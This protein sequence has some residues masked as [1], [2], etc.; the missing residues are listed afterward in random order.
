MDADTVAVP[1]P[2]ATTRPVGRSGLSLAPLG[3]GLRDIG[4]DPDNT[5]RLLEAAV[6]AGIRY[7]DTAAT[8]GHGIAETRLGS[9]LRRLDRD[10][11]VISIKVG[12]LLRPPSGLRRRVVHALGETVTGGLPGMQL[13]VRRGTRA[14]S[15][16]ARRATGTGTPP[17]AGPR[18]APA[19]DRTSFSERCDY[20]YDG[21][22]R[23]FEESLGRLGID[24]VGIA[25][26]HDPDLHRGQA[27]RGAY[28]ALERLRSDGRVGA[29]GVAMN[30]A[31]RL[32][33]FA[34]RGDFDVVLLAGRYSLLDQSAAD[35]LFPLVQRRGMALVLGGAFN[36][37]LLAD[38][39][40][41]AG[42]N[43]G[44]P[45]RSKLR[46]AR[47]VDEI[48]TG[49]GVSRKAAALQFCLAHPAVTTL[50]LGA[51]TPEQL[52]ESLEDLA[53]PIPR[54]V[55]EDLREAGLIQPRLPLPD[56]PPL[57]PAT[58]I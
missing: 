10:D 29:I 21:T 28:R 13:A 37:G 42:Y 53:S 5:A 6:A 35:D 19:P 33:W 11:L 41:D 51:A 1:P 39:R 12:Q 48:C 23:S 15:S 32:A 3:L 30:H 43:Y 14:A 52:A 4:R 47:R 7:V 31:G 8:Y 26:I 17:V 9:E 58:S 46:A 45:S 24:R 18:P 2:W 44:P 20:S 38:P 57:A 50:L 22:M 55:W 27:M 54:R 49:H 56:H 36:G 40:P 34:R 16:I 25:F